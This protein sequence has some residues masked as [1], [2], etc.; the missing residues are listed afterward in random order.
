M[1]ILRLLIDGLLRVEPG[2]EG[3]RVGH[4]RGGAERARIVERVFAA[5]GR[6][7]DGAIEGVDREYGIAGFRQPLA[8]GAECG[9]KAPDVR[10]HEHRGSGLGGMHEVGVAGAVGGFDLHFGLGDFG[11]RCDRGQHGGQRRAKAQGAE[12]AARELVAAKDIVI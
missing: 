1:P 9:A 8:H 7:F 11:G 12:L 5:G 3:F 6:S 2:H 10:P 4:M